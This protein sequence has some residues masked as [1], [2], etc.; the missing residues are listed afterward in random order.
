MKNQYS[1]MIAL[2]AGIMLVFGLNT[3]QAQ[4]EKSGEKIS[5]QKSIASAIETQDF[6]F[7]AQSILPVYGYSRQLSGGY[8]LRITPDKVVSFL[9][10]M[11]RIYT[12]PIDPA[13]GPLRFTSTDFVY[14]EQPQKKGGW[15]ISIKPKDVRTVREFMLNI[16]E[17]GYATLQVS[18]NDRQPVTFY[19]YITEKG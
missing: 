9:P 11:G 19:G 4:S 5:L 17:D 13:G 12:P 18:G 14:A 7:R 2:L 8:D 1:A 10:Y 6:V 3:L 15:N 16:S